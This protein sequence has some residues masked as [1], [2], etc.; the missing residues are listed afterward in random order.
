MMPASV[1]KRTTR[2]GFTLIEAA[3]GSIVVAVLLGAGLTAVTQATK[4]RKITENRAFAQAFA[5]Q[6]IEGRKQGVC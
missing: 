1:M 2:A 4:A 6:I 3:M 5:Q